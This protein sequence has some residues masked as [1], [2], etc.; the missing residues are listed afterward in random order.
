MGYTTDFTGK[1]KLNKKLDFDTHTYLN[2]FNEVRH[3]ARNMESHGVDYGV[4]GE[5]YVH[6]GGDFGQEH[7]ETIVSYNTPPS[8][9][10]SLWCGWKPTDDGLAIEWDGAEKFYSYVKWIK[11][12]IVNFLAP[13]GYELN[14]EVEYQGED[15]DDFGIIK[16]EANK[17]FIKEGKKAF[18]EPKEV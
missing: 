1:F 14:G 15:Q 18:S 8:T 16:I 4:E 5:F 10:P 6:G 3:M 9:Q 11:Y 7:D 12:I 17:V 2:R 13:K